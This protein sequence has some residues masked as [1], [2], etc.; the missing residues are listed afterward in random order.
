MSLESFVTVDNL[1]YVSYKLLVSRYS[2]CGTRLS[3][4]TRRDTSPTDS[5]TNRY[6]V[7]WP[8]QQRAKGQ[9][10]HDGQLTE[11]FTLVHARE[12]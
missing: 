9:V 1:E 6:R 10:L 7:R 11:D 4:V 3:R 2:R 8:A 5:L 12:A